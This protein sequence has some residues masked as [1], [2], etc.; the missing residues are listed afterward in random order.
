[1]PSDRLFYNTVWFHAMVLVSAATVAVLI[2]VSE[3]NDTNGY[4]HR[5]VLSPTKL[6]HNIVLYGGY[7]YVIVV[8]LV[9][10]VAGLVM[11]WNGMNAL[12]LIALL[13]PGFVWISLLYAEQQSS[14]EVKK[15]R[16]EHAH[17]NDWKPI[18]QH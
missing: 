11:N 17:V 6:Y 8:V 3:Y 7:G 13:F 15:S 12:L 2:T 18:W 16:I 1:L 9:A 14:D 10:V 5:A 4:G